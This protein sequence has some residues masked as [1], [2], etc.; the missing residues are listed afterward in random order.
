ML[1]LDGVSTYYGE[2]QVLDDISMSVEEGE[3]LGVLGRNGAG[4]TTTLRTILGLVKPRTGTVHF[5]GQDI[6]DLPAHEISKRGI[7]LVP[8]DR[9]IV[10]KFTVMENLRLVTDSMGGDE[11]DVERV[12]ELFPGLDDRRDHLGQ[13]LSGGQQQMLAIGRALIGDIRLLLLDEPLEGLAPLIVEDV[14]EII[15]EISETG[16]TI[17]L[18]EQDIMNAL[19]VVDRSYVIDKGQIVHEDAAED[20]RAN[21]E[22]LDEYLG[23]PDVSSSASQ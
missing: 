2:S 3:V 19:D 4:K 23:I 12:F 13:E 5:D 22:L 14:K 15:D 17:L 10:P 21:Q 1:E 18:V 7:S 11:A 16:V 8:E 9:R 6:T 20:V